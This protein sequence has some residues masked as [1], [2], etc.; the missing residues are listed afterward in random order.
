MRGPEYVVGVG[1]IDRCRRR[2][3]FGD[4]PREIFS[5]MD[6]LVVSV[7]GDLHLVEFWSKTLLKN[8]ILRRNGAPSWTWFLT[9]FGNVQNRIISV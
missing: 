6:F 1:L 4:Y 5:E 7:G 9:I 3:V 2:D 8:T